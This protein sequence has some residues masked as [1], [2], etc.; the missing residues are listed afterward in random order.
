MKI[1]KIKYK[2]IKFDFFWLYNVDGDYIGG[3]CDEVEKRKIDSIG[4]AVCPW[5]I[6]KYGLYEEAE[7]TP[8]SVEREI[9]EYEGENPE[10]FSSTCTVE[11]CKNGVSDDIFLNWMDVEME[12]F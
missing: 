9:A 11:G 3:P 7:R 12:E 6:K 2:G 10:D 8:E 5:C 4:L 1:E